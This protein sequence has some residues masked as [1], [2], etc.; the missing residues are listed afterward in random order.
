MRNRLSHGLLPAACPQ[1]IQLLRLDEAHCAVFLGGEV[2]SEIGL[3][4]KATL[5]PQTAITCA[6]ANGLIAYVPSE[7]AY[8]L[9][10]YE[11][12]GSYHLFLRPAPFV[13][14][15]ETRIVEQT[16]RLMATLS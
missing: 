5:D 9:G 7:A 2:L 10:G 3:R 6:Y 4:I 15:V 12:D 16:Q 11:V 13:R 1:E 8:G 14:N